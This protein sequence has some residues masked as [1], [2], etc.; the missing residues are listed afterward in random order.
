MIVQLCIKINN[1]ETIVKQLAGMKKD[2]YAK[3]RRPLRTF[4]SSLR[5]A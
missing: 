2:L 3:V 4:L 1:V 5:L